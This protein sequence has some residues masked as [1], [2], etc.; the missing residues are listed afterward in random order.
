MNLMAIFSPEKWPFFLR[1][2]THQSKTR[3]RRIIVGKFGS[4]DDLNTD[5]HVSV[6]LFQYIAWS[7]AVLKRRKTQHGMN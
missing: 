4:L 5:K 7:L 6:L 2:N 1:N 3:Q